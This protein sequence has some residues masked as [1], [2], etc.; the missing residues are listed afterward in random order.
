MNVISITYTKNECHAY[1]YFQHG[2]LQ[3]ILAKFFLLPIF[4][5]FTIDVLF[6]GMYKVKVCCYFGK[7]V[8]FLS[9]GNKREN[10][11][12][13]SKVHQINFCSKL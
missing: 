13:C 3:M 4:L 7:H 9:E 8:Q 5:V 2:S 1:D 10:F 11:N 12:Y 6:A